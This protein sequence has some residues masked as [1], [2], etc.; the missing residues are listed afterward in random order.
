M[1]FKP[2][3]QEGIL[4][5]LHNA[6]LFGMMFGY[7]PPTRLAAL[8]ST[9]HPAYSEKACK[10]C[11]VVGC[12]GNS[13]FREADNS[14]TLLLQHHKVANTATANPFQHAG[15]RLRPNSSSIAAQPI[16][17]P[18]PHALQHVLHLWINKGWGLVKHLCLAKQMDKDSQQL[19][20]WDPSTERGFSD[21]HLSSWFKQ[22]LLAAG[23]PEDQ[24]FCPQDG[25]HMWVTTMKVREAAGLE[26][27]NP[28]GQ[29]HIMGHGP[30]QWAAPVYNLY[31]KQLEAGVAAQG[32]AQLRATM[33]EEQQQ[34]EAAMVDPKPP[35]KP[36]GEW[37]EEWDADRDSEP[38]V[39]QSVLDL[40]SESEG[41][42]SM[43]A[44]GGSEEVVPEVSAEFYSCGEEEEVGGGA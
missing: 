3:E 17:C 13:I 33:L 34:A 41:P 31:M 16:R 19:L 20:F 6:C 18:I 4:W 14:Y 26:V 32:M 35:E 27:P 2:S 8:T 39:Q 21:K 43:A 28:R 36:S 10:Q 11:E 22:Q 9:K 12:T 29:A 15:K 40:V 30:Q 5:G 42:Q 24:L 7:M 38:E 25:R 37:Q 1:L 23:V 44:Q